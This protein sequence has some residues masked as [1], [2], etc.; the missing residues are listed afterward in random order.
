MIFL[1]DQCLCDTYR[2]ASLNR[3]FQITALAAA[4]RMPDG[5]ELRDLV[6]MYC[7]A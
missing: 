3:M 4:F 6:Y 7:G 1:S 5:C 2:Q